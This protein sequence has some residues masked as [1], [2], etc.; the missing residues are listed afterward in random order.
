[1]HASVHTGTHIDTPLHCLADGKPTSDATLRDLSGRVAYFGLNKEPS[2][3]VNAEDLEEANPDIEEGDVA[4]LATG[5]TDVMWGKFPDYYVNSPYLHES[6]ANW[7]VERHPT[8][9]V[10]TS[11]KKSAPGA[12]T[13]RPRSSLSIAFCWAPISISSSTLLRC[14]SFKARMQ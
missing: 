13:S 14:R 6:A 11:S 3:P 9:V 10:L 5:W 1:M 8:A 7:L 4:V 12:V 2:Q